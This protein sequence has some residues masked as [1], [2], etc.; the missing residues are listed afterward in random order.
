[1]RRAFLCLVH[2]QVAIRYNLFIAP[3]SE[4]SDPHLK[5]TQT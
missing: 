3:L 1:M 5:T 2:K 4:R